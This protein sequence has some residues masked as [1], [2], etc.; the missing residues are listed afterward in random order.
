M[1]SKLQAV[2]SGSPEKV[3][4]KGKFYYINHHNSALFLDLQI[5]QLAISKPVEVGKSYIPYPLECNPG[6][7]FSV[8]GF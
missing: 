2:E 4:G 7:L 8:M 3:P 1:A 5:Q 6:L